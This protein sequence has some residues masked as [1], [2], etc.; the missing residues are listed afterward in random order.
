MQYQIKKR[1]VFLAVLG[2][3]LLL[4]GGMETSL[5]VSDAI[6]NEAIETYKQWPM[7]GWYGLS[8]VLALIGYIKAKSKSE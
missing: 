7:A 5:A 1:T 6:N 3:F 8:F 4:L 2:I